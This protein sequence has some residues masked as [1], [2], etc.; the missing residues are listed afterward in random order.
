MHASVWV[1]VLEKSTTTT[2]API[3]STAQ[4]TPT[5]TGC[6]GCFGETVATGLN[7]PAFVTIDSSGNLFV[8]DS[9]ASHITKFTSGSTTGTVVYDGSGGYVSPQGVYIVSDGTLYFADS[10]NSVVFKL[11]NATGNGTIVAGESDVPGGPPS[12][13]NYPYGVYADSGA[14]YVGDAVNNVVSKFFSNSTSGI[15]GTVVAGPGLLSVP[16]GI[17]V[18]SSSGN[19]YVA[20]NSNQRVVRWSPGAD[21]STGGVVMASNTL[22]SVLGVIVTANEQT[23]F[24][25]DDNNY[26]K[27]FTVGVDTATI[28][29]GNGT[30]GSGPY[31]LNGPIGLALDST[32]Q[33]LYVVD[34]GNNRVQRFYIPS[35]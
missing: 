24:V 23:L 18:V 17:Y 7:S 14:F 30:A 32:E 1:L 35:C 22:S 27:K 21:P 20:D 2:T 15:N 8:S 12:Q 16:A 26:V 3:T 19:L 28:F 33:Y 6:P 25:T 11:I 34:S 10:S 4:V 9:G 29:A 5:T 13:F 31:Q